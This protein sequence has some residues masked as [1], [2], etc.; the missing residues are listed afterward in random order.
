MAQKPFESLEESV[1]RSWGMLANRDSEGMHVFNLHRMQADSGPRSGQGMKPGA[2][3]PGIRQHNS[4]AL[5]G[6]GKCSFPPPLQ[7]DSS[8]SAPQLGLKPQPIYPPALSGSAAKR[9]GPSRAYRML[10]RT[11]APDRQ[12]FFASRS[13]EHILTF[14]THKIPHDRESDALSN[15]ELNFMA[16]GATMFHPGVP[17]WM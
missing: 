12:Q 3:A 8:L 13:I 10:R 14:A 2:S 9:R 17:Q 1:Y 4:C 6:Q 15:H 5:K 16:A 7:G 11:F